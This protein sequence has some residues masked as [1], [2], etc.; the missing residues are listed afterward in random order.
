MRGQKHL[1][2][3]NCVLPQFRK[4]PDPPFH[5]FVVFSIVE[6]DGT[7]REKRAQ[8]NNC[9]ALHIVNDFC[10]STVTV[11]R[12]SSNVA[13]T[14]DDVKSSIPPELRVALEKYEL[15]LATWEQVQFTVENEMWGERV[16]LVA[17]E[18]SKA[19]EGKFMQ[20]LGSTL[21]KIGSFERKK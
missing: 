12:D 3:C 6:D 13:L 9:S 14:I 7:V 16:I 17:E 8:C 15:D 4:M 20:I 5:K 2:E 19:V 1:I 18:S 10:T 11:G 21:F